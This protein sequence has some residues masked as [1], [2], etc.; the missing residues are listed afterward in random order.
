MNHLIDIIT[1]ILFKIPSNFAS[2]YRIT[3]MVYLAD[4]C[5]CVAHGH[6]LTDIHWFFDN[7]GPFV[8]DV[9]N[10]VQ[11]N[12]QTF[13]I[14]FD[15]TNSGNEKML[16]SL[17]PLVIMPNLPLSTIQLLDFI[18]NETKNL[19]TIEFTKLV[20]NT[21]PI[22]TT[23]RYNNLNLVEKANEYRQMQRAKQHN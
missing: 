7:Y 1:Y 21:Y 5:S 19:S 20:Y 18:L 14:D 8:W 22:L 13:K 9:Y 2:K 6:Q 10:V 17:T 4:W 3:K 15:N 16:F 23:P 11:N 12:P